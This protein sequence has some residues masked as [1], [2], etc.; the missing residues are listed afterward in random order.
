M[1]GAYG[2]SRGTAPPADL[3]RQHPTA[4]IRL[5][6]RRI[7]G[8]HVR[9]QLPCPLPVQAGPA[10]KRQEGS[11][12]D[13]STAASSTDVHVLTIRIPKPMAKA[14]KMPAADRHTNMNAVVMALIEKELNTG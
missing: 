6:R 2:D 10:P 4:M 5:D 7:A 3:V 9:A 12:D 11:A 8:T 13:R 14:L 1:T